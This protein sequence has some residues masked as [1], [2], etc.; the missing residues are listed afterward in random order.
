MKIEIEDHKLLFEQDIFKKIQSYSGENEKIGYLFVYNISGTKELVISEI[1]EPHY[2][3]LSTPIFS[4]ISAKHAKIA[5][6]KIKE[7]NY[8]IAVIGFYHTHPVSFGAV[9]SQTDID[10]FKDVSKKSRLNVFI[11]A[12]SKEL[13]IYIYK[14]GEC[15]ERI[16]WK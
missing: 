3:D 13:V 10:H 5:K 11:I 7:S 4:E 16:T 15:I 9:R 2:K 1:T 6:K 12:T 8:T 14:Y